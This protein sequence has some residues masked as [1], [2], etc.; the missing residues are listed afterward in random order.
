MRLENNKCLKKKEEWL[1]K[2]SKKEMSS[3]EFWLS[4]NCKEN[5]SSNKK[6]RDKH[7]FINTPH[8]SVNKFN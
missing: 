2:L 1:I 7:S 5:K 8:K 4:K 6:E 3:K